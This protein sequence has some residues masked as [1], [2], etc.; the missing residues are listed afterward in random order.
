[1]STIN[2]LDTAS[3]VI[4]TNG[5]NITADEFVPFPSN[6]ASSGGP[7]IY[8]AGSTN[9]VYTIY[10][11]DY[12]IIY[13]WQEALYYAS[14]YEYL[15][16]TGENMTDA[17]VTNGSVN[18]FRGGDGEN[19]MM[20]ATSNPVSEAEILDHLNYGTSITQSVLSG[21]DMIAITGAGVQVDSFAGNDYVHGG[22]DAD[23][24]NGGLG[25]DSLIGS[26]G[27][28]VMSGGAGRDKLTGGAGNDRLAGNGG[29][30][31]LLGGAGS[32]VL[33]GHGGRDR[34]IG[35]KGDDTMTG[36]AGADKFIFVRKAGSDVITD[37]D[38]ELDQI[39]LRKVGTQSIDGLEIT[40]QG[41]D[42][43]IDYGKGDI[44]LTDISVEEVLT[45]HFI[46]G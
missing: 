20:F 18:S 43:L 15:D 3:A 38:V 24:I 6:F 21:D 32:D 26:G 9:D 23:T 11:Q 7:Y 35:A 45:A 36:G 37:F 25:H 16:V 17:S 5:Y 29:N 12:R 31:K 14:G 44:T 41:D 19:L 40:A 2:I 28:D 33:K 39:I 42:V 27:S 4:V 8:G 10:G 46:F 22:S 13:N 34:L 1:M 30:D